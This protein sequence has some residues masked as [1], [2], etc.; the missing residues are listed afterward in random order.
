[1]LFFK[2]L[3]KLRTHKLPVYSS[4]NTA[5]CITSTIT[6]IFTK[7]ITQKRR[8]GGGGTLLFPA[9]FPEV[10]SFWLGTEKVKSVLK[11]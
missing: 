2:Y 7:R 4:S 1:M 5:L 8:G 6:N 3:T 11:K 9:S 10:I